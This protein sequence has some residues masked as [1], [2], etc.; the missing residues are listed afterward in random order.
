MIFDVFMFLLFLMNVYCVAASYSYVVSDTEFSFLDSLTHN[1]QL[2]LSNHAVPCR[3]ETE[4]VGKLL[5][6]AL[7]DVFI[8]YL[9]F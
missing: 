4:P 1:R 6:V 5:K 2:I 7:V 8:L 9:F 3:H